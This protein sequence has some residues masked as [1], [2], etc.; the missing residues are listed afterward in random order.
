M[1]YIVDVLQNCTPETY[2]M[3]L[4]NVTPNKFNKINYLHL[5]YLTDFE[6]PGLLLK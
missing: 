3:L 2:M 5:S 4:T 1:Q 6:T